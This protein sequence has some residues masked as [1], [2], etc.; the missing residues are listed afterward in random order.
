[1]S[2]SSWGAG[3]KS[4]MRN[5]YINSV[6]NKYKILYEAFFQAQPVSRRENALKNPRSNCEF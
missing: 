5:A 4:Y 3:R 2:Y 6:L 1:M